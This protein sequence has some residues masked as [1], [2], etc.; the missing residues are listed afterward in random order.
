MTNVLITGA[1]GF[2]GSNMVDLL[3][4]SKPDWKLFIT[5]RW[6]LSSLKNVSHNLHKITTIDCDIT[7]P[8]STNTAINLAKPD[9]IF[10]FAAES[11]VSPSWRNPT[12]YM[13]VNYN[14]TL[15]I[16]EAVRS[17]VPNCIVHIPGSGEEYGDISIDDLPITPN[18]PLNPVNPY[19]VT[20]VAQDLIAKVYYDSYGLNV[21]RTR[22][23][24]HEGPRRSHHFG[25]PW[26]A[27]QI[28]RIKNG[29][30]EPVLETGS[31][32]DKETLRTFMICAKLIYLLCK[33]VSLVS[34]TWLAIQVTHM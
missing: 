17:I 8:H 28:I 23:F 18:T 4:K 7:D 1:T 2:V 15:N 10:H 11:F 14:G 29:L 32:S 20:K 6:H 21:I 22:S 5:K 33:S 31:T 26:Y 34:Y 27:Y 9:I 16:L 19:A 25:L 13:S 12:R 24:N 30:Q 3:I